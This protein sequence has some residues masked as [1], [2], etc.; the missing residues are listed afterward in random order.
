[1]QT[2]GFP[3]LQVCRATGFLSHLPSP[4]V[5]SV[6]HLSESRPAWVSSL[7]LTSAFLQYLL[8]PQLCH[9]LLDP[10]PQP[11]TSSSSPLLLP[12]QAFSSTP[13]SFLTANYLS[14]QN[15]G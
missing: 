4:L 12:S 5:G 10:H 14:A 2:L 11:S 15:W 13:D 6:Q 7:G 1:M 9:L 3:Q 8:H